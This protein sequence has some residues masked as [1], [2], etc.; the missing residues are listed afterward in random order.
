MTRPKH[1]RFRRSLLTRRGQAGFTLIEMMIVVVIVGILATLAVIGVR[2]YILSAKS[3]EAIHM[4]GAIKAAQES[5]KSE[6]FRYLDVSA[7][8]TTFYPRDPG[9]FKSAWNN[10]GHSDYAA[11]N[12]LGVESAGPVQ[13]GYATKAGVGGTPPQPGT[14][15]NIPYP[16]SGEPW[17]VVRASSDLNGN[18][19][20]SIY[21]SSS[22]TSEIY[23]EG[24]G[25]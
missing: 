23:F 20:L 2:K 18:G 8:L 3:N 16:A 9:Q 1:P 19:V 17:Y 15:A 14:T 10:P 5:Y 24:E 13:F 25:E 6:T 7:S 11:W 12:T 21:T 22:F 4:I